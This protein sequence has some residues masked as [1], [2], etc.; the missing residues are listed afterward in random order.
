MAVLLSCAAS[1]PG[2]FGEITGEV[3]DPSGSVV[4]G[5]DV[6]LVSKATGAERTTVKWR[7]PVQL[8]CITAGRYGHASK[9]GFQTTTN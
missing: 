8:S 4:A 6:K 5:S 7:R 9:Q 3:H 1:L 2:R